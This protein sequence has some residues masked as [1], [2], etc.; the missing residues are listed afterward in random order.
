MLSDKKIEAIIKDHYLDP[1]LDQEYLSVRSSLSFMLNT[2]FSSTDSIFRLQNITR[3]QLRSCIKR[4]PSKR[5]PYVHPD[6]I[7]WFSDKKLL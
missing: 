4:K 3:A 7:K 2:A 6:G 5:H 1:I